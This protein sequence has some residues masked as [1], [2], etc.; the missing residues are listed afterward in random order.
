MTSHLHHQEPPFPSTNSQ[1]SLYPPFFFFLQK[2]GDS[3]NQ[4]RPPLP[5]FFS[6]LS[7]NTHDLP[8][9]L[10]PSP[11]NISLSKTASS[12]SLSSLNQP[13]S[14]PPCSTAVPI[15]TVASTATD[16]WSSPPTVAVPSSLEIQQPTHDSAR[17]TL[18]YPQRSQSNRRQQQQP[19]L[20]HLLQ[21]ASSSSPSTAEPTDHKP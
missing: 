5:I 18:S 19:P 9:Q 15:S 8:S 21:P 16:P 14:Q 13:P 12:S 2:T 10:L 11:L 7:P 3:K 1:H 20:L 17:A 4:S 6:S